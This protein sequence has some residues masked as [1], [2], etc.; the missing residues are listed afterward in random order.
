M[1]A[2]R[3]RFSSWSTEASFVTE[4]WIVT[5]DNHGN[6]A[7][8]GCIGELELANVGHAIAG[9]SRLAVAIAPHGPPIPDRRRS[10]LN[11]AFW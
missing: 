11:L 8:S 2:L 9:S 7:I 4:F 3:R 6:A 1:D 10:A 5:Q